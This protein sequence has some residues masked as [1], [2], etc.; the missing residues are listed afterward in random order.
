MASAT[1]A[2]TRQTSGVDDVLDMTGRAVLVTGGAGGVG[3][4]ITEA[5]LARGADVVICGRNEPD[6]L[7]SAGGREAVF[8]AADVRDADAVAALVDATDRRGSGGSTWW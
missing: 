8:T 6:V 5:F 3:R 1:P 4:G 7:P 2:L